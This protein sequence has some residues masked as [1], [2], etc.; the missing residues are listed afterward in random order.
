[1]KTS[2][3]ILTVAVAAFV[4]ATANGWAMPPRQHSFSGVITD[5]DRDAHTITLA[6]SKS[7]QPLVFVCKDSTR[8]SRGWSRICLGT[9]QPGQPVKVYY[10]REIGQLVPREVSLRTEAPTRCTIGC[11]CGNGAN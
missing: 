2:L 3:L 1:M 5:I 6:P 9:L 7:N 4:A 8:F 10:R 11:A